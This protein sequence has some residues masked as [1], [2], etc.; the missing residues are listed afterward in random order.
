MSGGSTAASGHN[1]R[2]WLIGIAL[3]TPKSR[4]A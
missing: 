2:A 1:R 4:A 3:R